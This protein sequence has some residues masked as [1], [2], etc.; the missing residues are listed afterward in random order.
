MPLDLGSA[1]PQYRWKEWVFDVRPWTPCDYT[2]MTLMT[3]YCIF[4]V[5]IIS[6]WLP[7]CL[8]FTCQVVSSFGTFAP[9]L[10]HTC[11]GGV[12]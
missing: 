8:G 1:V 11:A 2:R 4:V 10:E 6:L 7:Q 12:V 5:I 3:V 9:C